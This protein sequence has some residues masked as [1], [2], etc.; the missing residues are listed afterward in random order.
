MKPRTTAF[1]RFRLESIE[2]RDPWGTGLELILSSIINCCVGAVH[3]GRN[4]ATT[5][6][7]LGYIYTGRGVGLR[8]FPYHH[9]PLV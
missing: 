8:P 3:V 4:V 5:R 7:V 2:L 6:P 9:L 1:I